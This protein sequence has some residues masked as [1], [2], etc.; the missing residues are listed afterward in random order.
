VGANSSRG[1]ARAI[2]VAAFTCLGWAAFIGGSVWLLVPAIVALA[3]S[4]AVLTGRVMP[5]G[6][7]TTRRRGAGTDAAQAT[8]TLALSQK[9]SR[10]RVRLK[11]P[12]WRR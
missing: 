12:E 10:L 6:L 1:F 7:F 9:V 11:E 3:V 2:C 5:S 4:V 8:D